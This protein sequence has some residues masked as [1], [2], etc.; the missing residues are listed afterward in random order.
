MKKYKSFI[1]IFIIYL[2]IN[3]I[4][5]PEIYIKQ[6]FNGISAWAL[7]VL[8]SVLPFILLTKLL[9]TLGFTEKFSK[10]FAKPC[11]KIFN[12][13]PVSSFVFL[14]SIVSGYPVGATMTADL[15]Q[16][17]K[18]SKSEAF[19]MCSFCSTSGPMFILGA[20]GISMLKNAKYGYII[21][22]SHILGAF[23][24]GVFYRNLQAKNEDKLK[25]T[26]KTQTTKNLS[27][28]VLDSSLSIISVGTIIAIFFVVIYSLSPLFN[29]LPMQLSCI[30]EGIVEIT[31]GCQ[32][33]AYNF[34]GIL[35]LLATTFVISFG[36]FSTILQSMTFL[37]K[38][39]MPAK[40]FI[41]QKLSH[42]LFSTALSLILFFVI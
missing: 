36:G 17:G 7:N 26:N 28:I 1:S 4:I 22:I 9:N 10:I 18:I 19:R 38:I 35:C 12:C 21:L 40:I 33:I 29:L 5:S 25:Y 30:L 39:Q 31:K 16:S 6:T 15:Y 11:K 23:I 3:M 37:S 42:A 13:P 32:D 27:D 41:F 20:V 14:S 24:N 2:I 8:P 34:S